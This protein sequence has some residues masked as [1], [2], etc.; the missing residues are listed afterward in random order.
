MI[1]ERL[2]P[3]E[4]FLVE[5]LS[6]PVHFAEFENNID[7][8]ELDWELTYY[9]KE[10]ICDFS[11]YVSFCCGR[12]VG[13]TISIS[14]IIMW[15]MTNNLFPDEPIAYTV[16][17]KVHLE[18]VFNRLTH[19]MRSNSL[20]K[21]YIDEK[22]GINASNY[23]IKLNNGAMLDCRI[24]GQSGTGQNVVGLHSPFILLDEAGFY[25]WGTW[26][27]LGPTLNSWQ[28]GF[29]LLVSGVPTGVREK[30]V[31]YAADE[32]DDNFSK[33]RVSAHQNPRYS[34]EDEER[35]L[36][37]YG[38]VDGDEYIHFVLGRHGNP[39]F[40]VFDRRLFSFLQYS[41]MKMKINGAEY[42][43]DLG[44]YINQLA[45]LPGLPENARYCIMGVDLG[46][47]DPTAISI[48]YKTREDFAFR[49]HARIRLEK[50]PYPV[51]ERLIDY[52]DSKYSPST[53]GIDEGSA[54]VST[55]HHLLNDLEYIHKQYNKKLIPINFAS[56]MVVAKNADGTDVT[57]KT[58]PLAVSVTQEYCNNHRI[59]FS[60]TDLEMVTELERMTYTTTPTG[61]IVYKTMT[62]KGGKRGE[63]HF[64]SA[65]LCAVMAYHSVN[66]LIM[67]KSKKLINPGWLR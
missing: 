36:K 7:G 8:Q 52:L 10:F 42:G 2:T 31:L 67:A 26:V 4:I 24:A 29:R 63:D 14:E 40:A 6:H 53:I 39:V 20:L 23:S 5:I 35:N 28:P 46:Y 48:L 17:N 62:E 43:S 65:L 15:A 64:T 30:N 58:K 47:T 54:G 13:K 34:P 45:L 38:G 50:T 59:I 51:Q 18:P 9:Q 66:E 60:T 41:V 55:V 49:F 27:E 11:S 19:K 21:I 61:D 44:K 25:P 57:T 3:D 12:A 32:I 33:H 22:K 1:K 37:Q 16:P 56:S